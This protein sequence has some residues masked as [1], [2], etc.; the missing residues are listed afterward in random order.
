M[1]SE[2]WMAATIF[3]RPKQ[4]AAGIAIVVFGY[5]RLLE[6]NEK[7][8]VRVLMV[9]TAI[10]LAAAI[11]MIW[12]V[13][14]GDVRTKPFGMIFFVHPFILACPPAFA[15]AILRHRVLIFRSSFVRVRNMRS[16][17]AP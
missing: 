3:M 10:S 4:R 13:N 14:F 16:L 17:A 12:L 11:A 1:A 8:R 15:Y 2:E 7:R 9:G 6:P 5:R